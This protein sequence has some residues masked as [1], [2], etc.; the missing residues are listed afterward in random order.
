M[1]LSNLREKRKTQPDWPNP[2]DDYRP[3]NVRMRMNT[4]GLSL[5][6]W[7]FVRAPSNDAAS[8]NSF[9][10]ISGCTI[11]WPWNLERRLT[12]PF[13]TNGQHQCRRCWFLITKTKRNLGKKIWLR[14]GQESLLI[15]E[16]YPLKFVYYKWRH[17]KVCS[18]ESIFL[19]SGIWCNC[20]FKNQ[21]T[22]YPACL[23]NR[24]IHENPDSRS[25][26]WSL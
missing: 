24:L 15:T 7:R 25:K 14:Q 13:L 20:Y 1:L 12:H 26:Y 22:S 8:E 16:R 4:R 2:W 9:L 19:F 5:A 17:M 3:F 23:G 18:F 21:N 10:T 6:K 11:P